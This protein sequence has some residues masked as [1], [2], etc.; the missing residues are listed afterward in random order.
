MNTIIGL[1]FLYLGLNFIILAWFIEASFIS[2]E[3]ERI[4]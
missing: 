3:Y 4:K 1:L 2:E